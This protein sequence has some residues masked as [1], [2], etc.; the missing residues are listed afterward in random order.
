[1][2]QQLPLADPSPFDL[3]GRFLR[4][5]TA[6]LRSQGPAAR[7][8][9][10]DGVT[11]W[12]VTRYEVLTR[13]AADDRVSR[14]AR[15]HWPGLSD[16]PPGWPLRPF[17]IAPTVLNAYGADRKRLREI[18]EGAFTPRRLQILATRLQDRVQHYLESFGSLDSGEVIDVKGQ[19]AR[20][21]ASETLCDLFGV[22]QDDWELGKIAFTRLLSPSPDPDAAAAD[23][24]E[25][26]TFL[27]ELIASKQGAP[28]DDMATT[29]AG[30]MNTTNEERV[31]ALV[32]TVAGGIPATTELI[33]NAV[34]NLL[35]HVD[36]LRGVLAGTA[37]WSA[38]IEET[39]RL[40]APV[41]HMPLRYAVEDIDLGEGVVIHRG[42]AI[43]MG[44][45]TGGRDPEIHG[46]TADI[47]DIHRLNKEHVAFGYGVHHCIGA[48]LGRLQAAIALPAL[49]ERFPRIELAVPAET[50][51]PLSTFVFHGKEQ[52]PIRLLP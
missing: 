12:S 22:R 47:F 42:D 29:L 48:P 13:L 10:P 4:E 24:D 11:A 41:Q 8:N 44:F 46:E 16:V 19:Y 7:V 52:L 31:L 32:V 34:F 45:G 38:V 30:A 49:F 17:L 23:V 51:E 21:I 43:L 1:M 14:D 50:L 35:R 37:S 15:Q 20:V 9:L 36:Q 6:R 27:S 26:M 5:Q 28:G 2:G 39:L 33:T 40:D 18:L 25:A 3:S